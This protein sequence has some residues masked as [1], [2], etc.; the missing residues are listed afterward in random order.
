MRSIFCMILLCTMLFTLLGCHMPATVTE[1]GTGHTSGVFSPTGRPAENG[2]Y[3]SREAARDIALA[4]ASLTN[5]QVT[6]VDIEFEYDDGRPEYTVEFYFENTEYEYE[7]H[8]ETGEIL[9][10]E[11]DK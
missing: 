4:H 1:G 5:D 10:W 3:I 6:R 11:W 2:A 9:S 7:I 8:A